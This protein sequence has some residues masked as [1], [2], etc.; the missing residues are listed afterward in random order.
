MCSSRF[1]TVIGL[2]EKQGLIMVDTCQDR[3][4]WQNRI[5]L[6][7]LQT[8]CPISSTNSTR[9]LWADSEGSCSDHK[10]MRDGFET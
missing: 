9:G 1:R 3:A 6:N 10:K 8:C 5:L 2:A 7:Y 4:P